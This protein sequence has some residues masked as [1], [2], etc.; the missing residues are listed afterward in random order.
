MILLAS[1]FPSSGR[2]K[3]GSVPVFPFSEWQFF[4]KV[5]FDFCDLSFRLINQISPEQSPAA[6]GVSMEK[7][8]STMI[9]TQPCLP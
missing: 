7:V 2:K 9:K 6:A 4:L 5:K 8:A 3:P 1:I